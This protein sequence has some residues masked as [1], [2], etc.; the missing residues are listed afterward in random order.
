MIPKV[1]QKS[2]CNKL[3]LPHER[4]HGCLANS[5]S[6]LSNCWSSFGSRT[7]SA[8]VRSTFQ[9][10]NWI[11]LASHQRRPMDCKLS[12]GKRLQPIAMSLAKVIFHRIDTQHMA[13]FRIDR[14]N[15]IHLFCSFK[16]SKNV[17]TLTLNLNHCH[18][19]YFDG[20][21][22][23]YCYFLIIP[24]TRKIP[25]IR[26]LK[27]MNEHWGFFHVS[28][29]DFPPSWWNTADKHLKAWILS[30]FVTAPEH[31]PSG[32]KTN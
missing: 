24:S 30:I 29:G 16:S 20:R 25:H 9:K 8:S 12:V 1:T 3:A 27:E 18:T 6:V 31:Y 2:R 13:C 10:Q 28:G 7:K 23:F 32:L 21:I 22:F 4:K 19:F 5:K 26:D 15:T 14:K 11:K 17:I